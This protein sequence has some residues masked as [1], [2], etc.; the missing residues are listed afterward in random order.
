MH[1]SAKGRST[2][3]RFWGVILLSGHFDTR[4]H[5]CDKSSTFSGKEFKKEQ[6]AARLEWQHHQ[7]ES[8]YAEGLLNAMRPQEPPDEGL[9]GFG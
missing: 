5:F 1:L 4:N 3:R 8:G 6:T 9:G 7:H 2:V